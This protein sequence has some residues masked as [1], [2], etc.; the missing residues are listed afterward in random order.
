MLDDAKRITA[1][2]ME[3]DRL[4][5]SPTSPF[6]STSESD[7]SFRHLGIPVSYPSTVGGDIYSCCKGTGDLSTLFPQ[8]ETRDFSPISWLVVVIMCDAI[9][10]ASGRQIGRVGLRYP[11]TTAFYPEIPS[12]TGT[13]DR[14]RASALRP[15]VNVSHVFFPGHGIL[16]SDVDAA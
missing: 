3:T 10:E 12:G 11:H 8:L 4:C 7:N 2:V 16:V 1:R 14:L 5:I 6:V 13:A 15:V 9:G